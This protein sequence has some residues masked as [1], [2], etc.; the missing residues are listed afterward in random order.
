MHPLSNQLMPSIDKLEQEL[1]P[2]YAVLVLCSSC[3]VTSKADSLPYP[4]SLPRHLLSFVSPR[5][6]YSAQ[7][8]ADIAIPEP[9]AQLPLVGPVPR[10]KPPSDGM[11]KATKNGTVSKGFLGVRPMSMNMNMDVRKWNWPGYLTFGSGNGTNTPGSND[12][13][14]VGGPPQEANLAQEKS[15]SLDAPEDERKVS[16]GEDNKMHLH[17][18]QP[19]EVVVDSQA[20]ED[21]LASADLIGQRTTPAKEVRT[22]Q[23]QD[24]FMEASES[25][26]EGAL[27]PIPAS[28]EEGKDRP[29]ILEDAAVTEPLSSRTSSDVPSPTRK[30]LPFF[31]IFVH[32][33]YDNPLRTRQRTV[34][35][36]KVCRCPTSIDSR[37]C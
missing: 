15:L 5:L 32:F 23:S 8:S 7:A 10:K 26:V 28:T 11:T 14:N 29:L 9:L 35:C 17:G 33:A 1:P 4:A 6:P 21:A 13:G 37:R 36:V 3:I 16:L 34:S 27:P 22:P 18:H 12:E 19:S 25:T 24:M 2:G 30:A 20:L 31:D